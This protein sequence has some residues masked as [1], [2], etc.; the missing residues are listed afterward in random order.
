MGYRNI[1]AALIFGFVAI[2]LSCGGDDGDDDTTSPAG[3]GGS[4]G[5]AGAAGKG[6]NAGKAGNAAAGKGGKGGNGGTS[7]AGTGGRGGSSG[8]GT[9]GSTGGTAGSTGGT[10][11]STGG[12][13]G[14]AG[15]GGDQGGAGADQGGQAGTGAVSN[16]GAGAGGEGG[17]PG[18]TPEEERLAKCTEVCNYQGYDTP[19]ADPRVCGGDPQDCID[20]LCDTA[21]YTQECVANLDALLVCLTTVAQ[22]TN[23]FCYGPN[24]DLTWD[25]AAGVD[26]NAA[27]TAYTP[28]RN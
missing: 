18:P 4:A 13:S 25:Y 1:T 12:S 16:G 11:G 10:G 27:F 15:A 7:T 20:D 8:G 22:P 23:F 17:A 21:G 6:G 14:T 9:G 2:P 24:D 26:C 19:D 5:K 28:C 3:K